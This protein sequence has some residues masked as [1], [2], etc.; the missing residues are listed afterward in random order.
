VTSQ[1]VYDH[2]PLALRD[3]P[4]GWEVASIEQVAVDVGSGFPSGAHNQEGRGVVHLR[5]MNVDRE[6]RLDLSEVKYVEGE[7]PRKVESGDVLFNNTNS[8][9]L[10]G[11]T[12]AILTNQ[13]L[14]YSNH[15]TR[16][17]LAA[18]MS[19]SFI[20]RQLHF[21]WI[22]GYFRHRCVNHVN[23]A[24]ISAEPLSKTVPVLVPPAAEQI[25][26]SDLLD[27]VLSDLDAGK[28]ALEKAGAKLERYRA[29]VLKAAVEGALTA[30]WRTE[31]PN[32]EPASQLLKRILA[33]RRHCWE[34]DQLRKFKEKGQ[35]P[36][37]N[38]RATYKEPVAPDSANLRGLPDGWC[39][40][41]LDQLSEIAGG[42][43][44]GQKFR[45]TDNTRV[46]PYLRVANV[47][48]GFLDLG[49]IKTIRALESDIQA[50]RLKPGDVLFNEGGD[51]DKLGRGW[52]WEGQ[53][54]ECIHQNHV[55]R[56]RLFSHEIQRKLVS[57]SGNSYGQRW[58]M[59]EGRQ[60]V[61]LASI[62]M[63]ILRS[64]PV[65]L[66]PTEEQ[67]VIVDAVEDQLSV[68]DHVE[69]DLEM[70]LESTAALRQSIL[71]DAL[72]GKLVPQDASDE[73]ASELLKRIAAERD[74]HTFSDGNGKSR[75]S[76]VVRAKIRNGRAAS[77]IASR[78]G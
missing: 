44:K 56:A 2:Y 35:V 62:N 50:L 29:S 51:R 57:W 21:L 38:W 22:T 74:A 58:F 41:T 28:A 42:V 15:M 69:K 26:I 1:L 19:S 6:G 70:K 59:R 45:A 52:I 65:P 5:P 24:S 20:A 9:E 53:I 8:P 43:T 55:F 77:Q 76:R 75:P 54:D 37:K 11:K 4:R 34:E 32:A 23:Q 36:P 72:A 12:T 71:L 46:V 3:L 60:S 14:A 49:E 25:R 73:P 40:A 33:E 68:L 16:I 66:A 17:R 10:I 30:Q 7:I 64:F 63:T 61:N 78:E 27:E 39:W 67:E 13:E 47:Q 18:G 31:H 48:R